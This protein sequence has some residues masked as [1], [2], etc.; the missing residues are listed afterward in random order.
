MYFFR[1]FAFYF[2]KMTP[3]ELY[4]RFHIWRL[5]HFSEHTYLLVISAFVG[6]ISGLAAVLLKTLVHTTNKW[7][8]NGGLSTLLNA[9]LLTLIYPAIGILLTILFVKFIIKKPIG[10]GI[11]HVLFAISRN[12]S[13]LPPT[14][15]YSSLI[16]STLTVAFGGSVGLEA[17]IVSTGSAI[18][19]NLGRFFRISRQGLTILLGCGAA[20]AIA[21]IFK[22][23]LAG[24]LFTVEV[25]M[26]NL[27][28]TTTVPLLISALCASTI[29]YFL[30]GSDVLFVFEV[31][32]LF[33]LNQLPFYII[34]GLFC[35]MASIYFLRMSDII[36]NWFA[37]QNSWIK[38]WITGS[39]TLGFLI[40]LFPPLLGEGYWAL[41]ELLHG[42]S[43]ALFEHS[44]FAPFSHNVWAA[45]IIL[46]LLILLKVVATATTIGCGG[47]GG[48]FGPSL[49]MGGLCGYFVALLSNQLGLP[50]QS[51]ANF[52]LVGMAAL[53]TGV[54]RAPLMGVFLIA[55]ITGGYELMIPL[56]FT[57]TVTSICVHPFEKHSIY[58]RKL[59]EKGDLLTHDKDSSAWQ[60]LDLKKLVETN[61][62]VIKQGSTLRQLINTIKKS[63]RNIFPVVTED[64]RFVGI[65]LLDDIR[66]IIF[67]PDLYDSYIVDDLM[68]QLSDGD[69]VCTND[70]LTDVV[71]KF[72]V[73]DRYNLIV[74][75]ED[76]RY[77]GCL[78]RANT[79]SAYRRFVRETT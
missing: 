5:R 19:S 46:M 17:P 40:F 58:A 67:E 30:M 38:R 29:S 74:L 22:A 37:K 36:E 4:K 48:T 64:N 52:A 20:G 47:V 65:I 76:G 69:C 63:S 32:E 8:M 27:T 68:H 54:M 21:G 78:S 26:L 73:S 16:A 12:K 71:N 56:L 55:E 39:A 3:T 53:I 2:L 62:S 44:I 72:K 25:L 7:V 60:L 23:P 18:G 59:A 24:V 28:F 75:D 35:A 41:S 42:N 70:S 33:E 66:E 49:V 57:S 45:L 10:H 9:N 50:E 43:S 77:Q 61:I 11:P 34:L 79:F 14:N 6:I 1:I 15:M 31:K 51:T 13:K